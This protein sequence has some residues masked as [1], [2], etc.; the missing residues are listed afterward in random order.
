MSTNFGE[1]RWRIGDLMSLGVGQ[2]M[3]SASPLQMAVAVSSL[4]NG[5]YKVQPHLVQAIKNSDGTL[6]Y[7]RP[8]MEK[9]EWIRPEYL[10]PVKKGMKRS[11]E[12]RV[13]KEW[14]TQWWR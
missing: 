8:V 12:R 10:E 4:A 1:R 13:G 14:R 6:E 5:G 11:E 7:T 3:V 9:I 2:G